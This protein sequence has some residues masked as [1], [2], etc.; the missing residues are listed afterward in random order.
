MSEYVCEKCNRVKVYV[1]GINVC[2][3]CGEFNIIKLPVYIDTNK[4]VEK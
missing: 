1:G 2:F 3:G 4:K